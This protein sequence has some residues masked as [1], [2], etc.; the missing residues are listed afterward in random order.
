MPITSPDLDTGMAKL[1]EWNKDA[2]EGERR[3]KY[4]HTCQGQG[5]SHGL[6]TRSGHVL[7]QSAQQYAHV[8]GN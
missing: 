6:L 7:L 5:I 4:A 1:V 8:L 2:V 3:A